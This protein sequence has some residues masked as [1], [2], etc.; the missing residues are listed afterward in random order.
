[1]KLLAKWMDLEKKF[2]WID[3]PDPIRQICLI[4]TYVRKLDFTSFINKFK[5]L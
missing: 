5:F 3:N 1:M 4:L 2:S